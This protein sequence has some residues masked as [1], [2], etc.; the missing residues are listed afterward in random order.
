MP[1]SP[2]LKGLGEA[3]V[4]AHIGARMKSRRTMLGISLA[5]LAD[6]L[7][8]TS[9]QMSKYE[10]GQ[11]QLSAVKLCLIAQMLSV[12]ISYFY[13]GLSKN[14]NS[15]GDDELLSRQ[16]FQAVTALNQIALPIKRSILALV[17]C[18]AEEDKKKKG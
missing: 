3:E 9:Q 12:D 2:K 13:D 8:I 18:L 17:H 14:T 7:S 6:A 4:A 16:N 5:A 15:Y 1:A 10:H 11:N